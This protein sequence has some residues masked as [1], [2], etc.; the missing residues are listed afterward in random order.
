M[1]EFKTAYDNLDGA[2]SKAIMLRDSCKAIGLKE[3]FRPSEVWFDG[4]SKVLAEVP[5]TMA[6]LMEFLGDKMH[7]GD[8]EEAGKEGEA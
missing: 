8:Q 6:D 4:A 5:D 1:N 3:D 2:I 7:E